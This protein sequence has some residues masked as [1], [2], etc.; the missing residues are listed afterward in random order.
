MLRF[1]AFLFGAVAYL[2]FL[3]TILYAI[4]FV[5]GLVVPKTIDTGATVAAS[6]EALA[7]N[8]APDVAVCRPAQRDGAQASSSNGG[9]SLFRNR[10]SAAPMCC[11][12]A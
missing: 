12:P 5:S 7:I 10:S 3:V 8:L 11:S 9:R 1:T 2:T 6:V 4:G